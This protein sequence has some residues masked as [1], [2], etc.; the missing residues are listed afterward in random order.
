[1]ITRTENPITATKDIGRWQSYEVVTDCK[2]AGSLL[3]ELP[4]AYPNDFGEIYFHTKETPFEERV[5]AVSY[6]N[7]RRGKIPKELDWI[8]GKRIVKIT[9]FGLFF[10]FNYHVELEV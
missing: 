3:S 7:G 4:R 5:F 6:Q 1:M 2:K 8:K 9:A 10:N